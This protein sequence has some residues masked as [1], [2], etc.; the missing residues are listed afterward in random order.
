MYVPASRDSSATCGRISAAPSEQFS[1]ATSGSACSTE[2]QNASSVCPDSVRPL[3][4][5]IVTEIHNG[6]CGATSRAAAIAAFA[7]SVSK[8]VSTSSRS[9]PPSA[10]ACTCSAYAA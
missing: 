3:R 8:I 2:R 6:R 9:T 5:T 10:S 7:L 4:S 1:P